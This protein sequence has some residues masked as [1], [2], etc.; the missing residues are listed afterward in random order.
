MSGK[1]IPMVRC[2]LFIFGLSALWW[3]I[4]GLYAFEQQSSI[5]RIAHH[6]I[7]GEPFNAALLRR[8]IPAIEGVENA[9]WCRQPAL[10]SAAIIRLRMVEAAPPTSEDL[11]SLENTIRSSLSCLPADPFLWLV[12][13]WVESAQNGVNP[14]YL[15]S[16]RMSY[17]LGPNEG[18]IIFKRNP[19]AFGNFA[20][21]PSDIATDAIDEF[22][23]L[24]KSELYEQAAEILSGPAWPVRDTILPRL[25]A[26]PQENRKDFARFVSAKGL[27]VAIPGVAPPRSHP[28]R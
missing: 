24:I 23:A 5:E 13:F 11:R 17:Q 6:I 10:R 27:D 12:L 20:R 21:L 28:W 15:N 1:L 19:V 16:L 26:L 14:E 7:L 8:Q 3:G 18:W 25:A 4:A 9:T 2:V 22:L